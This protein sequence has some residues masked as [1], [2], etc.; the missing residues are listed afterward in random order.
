MSQNKQ[1]KGEDGTPE[2]TNA[3]LMKTMVSLMAKVEQLPDK[4]VIKKMEGELTEKM[5]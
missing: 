1:K 4:T 2:P 5:H 3:E